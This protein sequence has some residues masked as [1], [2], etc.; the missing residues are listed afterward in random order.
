MSQNSMA[1]GIMLA[2]GLLAPQ[3]QAQVKPGNPERA[4]RDHFADQ[5]KDPASAVYRIGSLYN[6]PKGAL[7][8]VRIEGGP[9]WATVVDVDGERKFSGQPVHQAYL[10]LFDGERVASAYPG[11]LVEK[12][13]VKLCSPASAK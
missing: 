7:T 13:L 9:F 1:V 4:I 8:P 10:V 3:A 11:G 2:C 6:C 5:L 12:I